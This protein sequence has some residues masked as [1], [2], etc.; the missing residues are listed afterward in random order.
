MSQPA[1]A[2]AKAAAT[3]CLMLAVLFSYLPLAATTTATTTTLRGRQLQGDAQPL[4][5]RL[6]VPE[7]QTDTGGS[8]DSEPQAAPSL[9]LNS[10][11]GGPGSSDGAARREAYLQN[12]AAYCSSKEV[13][14]GVKWTQCTSSLPHTTEERRD[15]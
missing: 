7:S 3:S 6:D 14:R 2:A 12:I 9:P 1:A 10:Q 8:G 5:F 4:S 11:C 13:S 15:R